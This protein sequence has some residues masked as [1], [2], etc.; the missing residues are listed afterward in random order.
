[1]PQSGH[2]AGSGPLLLATI[3]RTVYGV[4]GSYVAAL[5]APS[6]P[7]LHAMVLGFIGLVMSIAGA[8][9]TWD[10]AAEFGP[11]WYPVALVVLAL[12][13]A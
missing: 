6:R 8:V 2:P 12:P 5:F 10:R 1:M 13:T 9:V 3:Y 7:M 4:L 11:H